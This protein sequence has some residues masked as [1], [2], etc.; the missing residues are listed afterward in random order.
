MNLGVLVLNGHRW[1]TILGLLIR[2]FTTLL[3][4]I[5]LTL[6]DEDVIVSWQQIHGF[7]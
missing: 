6:Q 1:T 3:T 7:G 5:V 2:A 4:S